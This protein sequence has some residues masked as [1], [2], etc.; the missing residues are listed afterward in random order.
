MTPE[1]IVRAWKDKTYRAQLSPAQRSEL[2]THPAG[3]A[4]LGLEDVTES[5]CLTSP[6]C[7]F[8]GPHCG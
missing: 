6:I 4:D 8:Y 2:P 3:N 1:M 7:T 5:P